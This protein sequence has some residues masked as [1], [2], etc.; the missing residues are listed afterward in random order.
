ISN[1]LISHL[2]LRGSYGS[3]GNGNISSYKYL[4]T[5]SVSRLNRLLDGSNPLKTTS[6]SVIPKGLTWEKVTT[7][8]I[9]LDLG[10]FDDRLKLNYDYFVRKTTGMYTRG[11]PLPDVF[12]ASEPKGNFADLKTVGWELALE[13]RDQIPTSHPINYG[14]Q[15]TLSDNHST[16][17]KFNNPEGLIGTHYEG[18]RLGEI[19]GFETDGLF[20]DID[21]IQNE[22][23]DQSRFPPTT[24]MR[25]DLQPGD[26]KFVDQDGD[27]K[28]TKGANTLEDPGDQKVIGNSQP[29]YLFGF[30]VNAAWRNFNLRLFFQGVGKKDWWPGS[31]ASFFW[32]QYGRPYSFHPRDVYAKQWGEDNPDA[33]FPRLVGYTALGSGNKQLNVPSTRYLQ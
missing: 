25:N 6:P 3:L 30:R 11:L 12:G 32:G 8:N 10:L 29:R 5:M 7:A 19:W 18:E 26:L 28:I 14:L 23:A 20:Q 1:D 22:A 17:T 24:H 21:E 4:E 27:G 16:V 33:Y 2:K 9:G 13:W 15:F 31:D